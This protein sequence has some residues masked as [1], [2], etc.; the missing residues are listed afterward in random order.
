MNRSSQ[1]GVAL[2]FTL[3]LVLVLS[4]MTASMM[5]LAQSETWSSLNYR[6]MTQTR[7]GAEAGL[8]AAANYFANTY[9]GV[10]SSTGFTMTGSPVTYSGSPVVLS[11]L[12]GVSSNYPTSSVATAFASASAG[13]LTGGPNTVK[14]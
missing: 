6:L 2:L 12:S 14:K 11:S 13:S 5:F 9:P 3:I 7:Y 4:V 1:K 8:N 10:S